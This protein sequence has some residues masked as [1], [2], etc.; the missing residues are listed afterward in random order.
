MSFAFH[1]FSEYALKSQFSWEA[2]FVGAALM[3]D[4]YTPDPAPVYVADIPVT[5]RPRPKVQVLGRAL[6]DGA[7][8]SFDV[9]FPK[10]PN[11]GFTYIGII[12]FIDT[13]IDDTSKLL[14]YIN[15]G[16]GWPLAPNGGNVV[17][18]VDAGPD[19]LF[20][21]GEFPV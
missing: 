13:A 10:V 16:I 7:A 15:S 18:Q 3:R 6:I 19:K 20:R 21:I 8:D 12:L 1:R 2:G 4:T 17:V 11:E 5:H 14:V 9:I